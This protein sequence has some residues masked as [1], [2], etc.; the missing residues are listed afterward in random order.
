MTF[1]PPEGSQISVLATDVD[2]PTILIPAPKNAKRYFPALF[3]MAWLVMWFVGLI[4]V[5]TVF[6]PDA[7]SGAEGLRASAFIVAWIVGWTGAGVFA[8]YYL[9]LFLRPT[10]PASLRLARDGI[11]FDSGVQPPRFSTDLRQGI[12]LSDYFPR[13][14]C[15][16]IELRQL[17]SLRMRQFETG[18]RLT[19]DVGNERIEIGKW[20]T[21]VERDWLFHLLE[22]RYPIKTEG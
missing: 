8:A 15:R 14:V 17:K 13:R 4:M 6:L 1:T 22:D 2:A 19:V 16:R 5:V 18:S 7:W 11:D 9:Y 20:A 3:L 21:D 10:V 12:N